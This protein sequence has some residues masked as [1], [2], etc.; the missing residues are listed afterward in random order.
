MP[1]MFDLTAGA[2]K[3]PFWSMVPKVVDHVT[4]VSFIPAPVTLA[5]NCCVPAEDIVGEAGEIM[6]DIVEVT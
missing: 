3:N 6:I 1:D 2:L 5:L 4:E